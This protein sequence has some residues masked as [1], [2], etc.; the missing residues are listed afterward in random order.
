MAKTLNAAGREW[1]DL[2][3]TGSN[4]DRSILDGYTFGGLLLE[5][6]CGI[7]DISPDAIRAHF[8]Q[9]VTAKAEEAREI[10]AANAESIYLHAIANRDND[11]DGGEDDYG[12]PY[13]K[14]AQLRVIVG[15]GGQRTIVGAAGYL[16]AKR[17]AAEEDQ[18]LAPW[19][20]LEVYPSGPVPSRKEKRAAKFGP[21]KERGPIERQHLVPLFLGRSRASFPRWAQLRS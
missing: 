17:E 13:G 20:T 9:Q 12:E 7:R 15:E 6:N 4:L 21:T 19:S 3:L 2:D 14:G 10:F 5:I 8:E 18:T 11:G 16:R 1:S